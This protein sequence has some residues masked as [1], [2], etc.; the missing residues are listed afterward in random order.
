[1]KW[2]Q[3]KDQ[4]FEAASRLNNN[5]EYI[6]DVGNAFEELIRVLH[7]KDPSICIELINKDAEIIGKIFTVEDP[8]SIPLDVLEK[9]T[10]ALMRAQKFL[11]TFIR[12]AH[13]YQ[14]TRASQD[15][16][17]PPSSNIH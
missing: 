17:T 9:S 3:I 16:Y 13:M 1:M 11:F 6:T 14:A 2:N 7:L 8:Q 10:E 4:F 12:I 15:T 5:V